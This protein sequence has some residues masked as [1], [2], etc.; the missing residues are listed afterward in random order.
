[1]SFI[2]PVGKWDK[3]LPGGD[4]SG[5]A[6]KE[7]HFLLPHSLSSEHVGAEP[8]ERVVHHAL[9]GSWVEA[10]AVAH[11]F[12]LFA[13]PCECSCPSRRMPMRL[14]MRMPMRMRTG[15]LLT[16]AF[17]FLTARKAIAV[18]DASASESLASGSYGLLRHRTCEGGPTGA[19][20]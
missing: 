14:P 19:I 2:L 12:A 11:A 20:D 8:P 10:P 7:K 17:I 16:G 5:L 15:L 13:C 9:A 18:F 1:M 4:T 3:A 6:I